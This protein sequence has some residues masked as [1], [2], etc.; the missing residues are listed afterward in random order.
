MLKNTENEVFTFDINGDC[1]STMDIISKKC[2][3]VFVCVPTD[4][5]KDGRL[6]MSIVESIAKELE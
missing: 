3:I 1:N 4:T 6:D 5:G 2:E